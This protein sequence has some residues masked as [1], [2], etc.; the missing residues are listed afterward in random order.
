M[1]ETV[2]FFVPTTATKLLYIREVKE[3]KNEEI[4]KVTRFEVG[5]EI[6]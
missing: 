6:L 1:P 3:I 4:I 2:M 5:I